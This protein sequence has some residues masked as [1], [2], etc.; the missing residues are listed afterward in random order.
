MIIKLCKKCGFILNTNKRIKSSDDVCLACINAETKVNINF[1]ERQKWLTDFIKENKSEQ[2][3][4]VIGVSGGKDSHM[5]VKRL[6]QNHNVKNPLL[7]TVVDEF[8]QTNAGKHNLYNLSHYFDC[9]HIIHRFKPCA[10]FNN[11]KNDFINE[12]H[13]LKWFEEKIYSYPF[14]IAKKFG[15]KLVF[16]GENSDFDYGNSTELNIFHPLSDD[17]VKIIYMGSI[18]PYSILDS[19]KEARSVNFKDLD[20]YNEWQRSGNI[21]NYTQIDSIGYIVHIWCKFVKFGFQR[22]S[23]IACRFVREKSLTKEQAELFIK[24]EDWKLDN[25]AKRDFCNTLDIT[26][27]FFDK[28]VEKHANKNLVVKDLNGNY[29]RRD[30][31]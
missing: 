5:I 27:D 1:I 18:Y 7:V 19:L 16:M 8:T 30:L 17:D 11:T 21:E 4:C 23:D 14:Q 22:V 13:P 28:I 9:E 6:M 12:L 2:F 15:I 20:Y 3:D 10:F 25:A 24:E 31:I 29:K 26:E